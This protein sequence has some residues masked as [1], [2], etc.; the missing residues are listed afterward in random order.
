MPHKTLLSIALLNA[1]IAGLAIG[2]GN[3]VTAAIEIVVV[4]CC[5]LFVFFGE[6]DD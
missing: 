5:I 4:I 6:I 3:Y 1:F 2:W